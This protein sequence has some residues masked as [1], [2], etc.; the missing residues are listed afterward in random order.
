MNRRNQW[1][2]I[3]F[4]FLVLVLLSFFLAPRSNNLQQG[5]TYSRAPGGYGAWYAEMQQQGTPIQR[6]QK[7]PDQLWNSA[8]VEGLSQPSRPIV[9]L[10]IGGSRGETT[11]FSRDWVRQGNILVQLGVP[12]PATDAPFSSMIQSPVGGVKVET[13]RRET[14]QQGKALLRDAQ[15]AIVWEEAIGVGRVVSAST[16][17]LAAN[18][19]QDEP[20]NFKFLAQLVRQPGYPIWVDEYLHGHKDANIIAQEGAQTVIGYLAKTPIVLL[21]V[22]SSLVLLILIWGLNQRLGQPIALLEPQLDNSEAYIQALAGVLRKANSHDF[23]VQ[24][25]GRAEQIQIQQSL[26]LGKELLDP[27]IVIAAWTEQTGR[28]ATELRQVLAALHQQKWSERELQDWLKKVQT[29]R[30]ANSAR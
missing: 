22:Q 13:S 5:S 7:P 29:V 11:S 6:W 12:V 17:F 2:G 24:T 3:G 14:S 8:G 15:G 28:S 4:A 10:R 30:Q 25:I 1:W 27:E 18:A 21:V 16:S 20:G 19:Y 9:L 23:V 26:R